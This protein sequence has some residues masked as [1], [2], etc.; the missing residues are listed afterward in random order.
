M[1]WMRP[2]LRTNVVI[3]LQGVELLAAIANSTIPCTVVVVVTK[4]SDALN[5]RRITGVVVERV[6][7]G[8]APGPTFEFDLGASTDGEYLAGHLG[9]LMSAY[10]T[11]GLLEFVR[12]GRYEGLEVDA[13]VPLMGVRGLARQVVRVAWNACSGWVRIRTCK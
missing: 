9:L 4:Q 8:A 10:N 6:L 2:S 1:V 5:R 13:P 12:G 3:M 11:A 7:L